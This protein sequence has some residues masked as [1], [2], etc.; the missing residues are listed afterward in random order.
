M[1]GS[2]AL[3][4]IAGGSVQLKAD[5]AL[6]TDE[7]LKVFSNDISSRVLT[8]TELTVV[9]IIGTSPEATLWAN[10]DITGS[11]S[12]GSFTKYA[13]GDLECHAHVVVASAEMTLTRAGGKSSGTSLNYV[14]FPV[15]FF[16]DNGI[17]RAVSSN[18]NVASVIVYLPTTIG[19]YPLYWRVDSLTAGA[20]MD[21]A[22]KGRWK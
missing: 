22:A 5:D 7:V 8:G 18:A 6:T 13:N 21:Y 10:G 20:S 11:S 15:V 17:V 19:F 16:G 2:I 14:T 4:A 1:S 12:N 9:G 3:K